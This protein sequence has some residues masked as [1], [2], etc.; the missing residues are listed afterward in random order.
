MEFFVVDRHFIFSLNFFQICIMF[1]GYIM[2]AF[3]WSVPY[4]LISG[5]FLFL[6]R[7][8]ACYVKDWVIVMISILVFV[9]PS[10]IVYYANT[11]M[12]VDNPIF[13]MN[14]D[15]LANERV[16]LTV[17]IPVYF[18][19]ATALFLKMVWSKRHVVDY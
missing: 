5:A 6:T 13:T 1:V 9:V 15:S 19:T 10:L 7:W 11:F 17:F 4:I 16:F 2:Y 3:L 8:L 14:E 12:F 18:I